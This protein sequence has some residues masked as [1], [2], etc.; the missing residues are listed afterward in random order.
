MAVKEH[1]K[2]A[3]LIITLAILGLFALYVVRHGHPVDSRL[4]AREYPFVPVSAVEHLSARTVAYESAP[5]VENELRSHL[6][7]RGGSPLI[8]GGVRFAS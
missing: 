7:G 5:A 1:V 2:A 4:D 6:T 8:A 3:M